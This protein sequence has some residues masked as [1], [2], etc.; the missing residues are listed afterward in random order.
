MLALLAACSGG[1]DDGDAAE[2]SSTTA[3]PEAESP[4]EQISAEALLPPDPTSHI[5][6]MAAPEAGFG[7]L[8]V[9]SVLEPAGGSSAVVWSSADGQEWS[10]ETLVGAEDAT[11]SGL[12]RREGLIAVVGRSGGGNEAD[13]G[14]WLSDDGKTWAPAQADALGGDGR[15]SAFDAAMSEDSIVVIGSEQDGETAAPLAW[16]SADGETWERAEVPV[17]EGDAFAA[18]AAGPESF[19][20]VGRGNDDGVAWTSEDGVEWT[21]AS[22]DTLGGPGT[23]AVHDVGAGP[24][25]FVAVGE[26]SPEGTPAPASWTSADG[27]EWSAPSSAL[28]EPDDNKFSTRAL[29]PVTVERVGEG[30]MA[31]GGSDFRP[32]VWRSADGITWSA[33]PSFGD[34]PGLDSKTFITA[35]AATPE[36]VMLALEGPVLLAATDDV[37]GELPPVGSVFPRGGASSLWISSLAEMDGTVVAVGGLEQPPGG[38]RAGGDRSFAMRGRD[39]S[40]K[41]AAVLQDRGALQDVAVAGDGFVAVGME[42]F[43]VTLDR[44]NDPNPDGIV[45][46]STDGSS[47]GALAAGTTEAELEMGMANAVALGGRGTQ[48]LAGVVAIDGGWLAVGSIALDGVLTPLVARFDGSS[49]AAE[50]V[51]VMGGGSGETNPEAVC[52]AAD[53][54][55]L[56]PGYQQSRDFEARLWQ[57]NPQGQWSVVDIGAHEEDHDRALVACAMASEGTAGLAVGTSTR[58]DSDALAVLTEDGS[59]WTAIDAEAFGTTGD[60]RPSGVAALPGGGWIVVGSESRQGQVDAAAWIVSDDG[61]VRSVP[62]PGPFG[63]EGRQDAFDVLVVGDEVLVGGMDRHRAGLWRAP[64]DALLDAP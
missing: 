36:R 10:S 16:T 27:R 5:E 22:A 1:G 38:G 3:V 33:L 64:L 24:A 32:V 7:W 18:V 29:L 13:A 49:V 47:F 40:W 26:H 9:G 55:V 19:V 6:T 28:P 54:T 44:A 57:R 62:G 58:G 42:S 45:R 25:G 4:F 43:D 51:S 35:M 61:E 17:E 59:T 23:Q 46:L 30:W 63:G 15:Q 14:I 20:I 31:A 8:A 34:L 53:G 21:R 37:W 56:V 52:A 2:G 50:D 11:A 60:Q 39:G 48:A 12:A 41:R